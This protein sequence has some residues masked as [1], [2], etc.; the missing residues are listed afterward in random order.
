M[1]MKFG[2]DRERTLSVALLGCSLDTGNRGVSALT[3]ATIR[4]ILDLHDNIRI[5]L[6]VGAKRPDN[7]R[8]LIGER[9]LDVHVVNYR[10]SPQCKLQEHLLWIVFAASIYRLVPVAWVRKRILGGNAWLRELARCDLIGDIRGGDSF[11]DIY[12]LGRLLIGILPS[13]VV[14]LLGKKLV[15]LP[16]TY[17]P[18]SSWV[19]RCLARFVLKRASCILSRDLESL[20]V[21]QS[22]LGRSY[23][24]EKILLCPDVAF[25]LDAVK[26]SVKAYRQHDGTPLVGMNVNALMYHGGYGRKDTLGLSLDYVRFVTECLEALLQYTKARILL[27]PHVFGQPGNINNDLEASLEV[28]QCIKSER[29][30]VSVIQEECDVSEIKG[31]IGTCDFFVGSRMH[32]CI[33]AVS[34]GIPTVAV[35]YSDKFGG[36]FG[37]IGL[38]DIVIDARVSDEREAIQTVLDRYLRREE[39]GRRTTQRMRDVGRLI[40]ETFSRILSTQ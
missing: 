25:R 12:G 1:Y 24:K 22:V 37:L 29:L 7:R 36:V 11:S 14:V 31:I 16:Q 26:P 20:E 23:E 28:Y 35:G 2:E 4:S 6:L 21:L 39:I 13:I 33:A 38:S 18:Y 30:R 40:D 10:L 34:Q 19:A 32:A 3:M 8:I 27:I 5:S 17:G 9:E 15:L